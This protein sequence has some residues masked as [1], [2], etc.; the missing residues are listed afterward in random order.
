MNA[1]KGQSP[2]T[3]SRDNPVPLESIL[4]TDQL[5][6]RP[7]RPADHETENRAL[8]ALA[9]A[10][11][12]SPPTILQKL[13]EIILEVLRAQSAGL[14]LLTKE[15]GGKRF[16]WPAIAGIWKQHVGGGTPRE[17]GPC[18]DVLDRDAP[19]LFRH[20]E[21]RYAY[22]QP[23]TPPVEECL[24]VPFYVEGKAVGTIWGIMHDTSRV[25]DAEDLRQLESLGRFAS[26]AYQAVESFNALEQRA[27]AVRQS[28]ANLRDF[29]ENA[30]IGLHWVGPDGIIIWA[31]QTEL[32]MLG[33]EREEYIGHDIAK[34]HV[35]APVIEDIL[36]RLTDGE[37]LCDYEARLRCKDGSIRTVH[38]NSNAFFEE[39]KFV[40]T[41]CFTHDITERKQSE[42]ALR[43]SEER[44]RTLFE[45]GP[46]AVYSCDTA[47]VIQEFN[48]RAA[49]LWGRAPELGDTDERF[50]GSFRLHRPDGTFMPHEQCPMAEVL[51]GKIPATHDAEVII[52]RPDGSRITVIVNIRPLKDEQGEV[53][54]A[55]NCF[56][57][58]TERVQAAEALRM[59]EA[60]KDAIL[61]S[62]L[63]AIITMDHEGRVVEFNPAAERI[64]GQA[65]EAVLGKPLAEVIIP[66]RM[67]ES[68]N[69]GLQHYLTTG[70]G[71]I[72]NQQIELTA[73]RAD[74]T[75]F[76]AELAIIVIPGI[77]PPIFTA[78]LRDV[79]GRKQLEDS[80]HARA[81]ELARAD[82]SKDEFLAM[83]AHELRNPLAPLRNASE[84]LQVAGVSEEERVQAQGIISRQI[85]NM[86]RMIDD[87]LDV[88]RIAEGKI[89]LRKKPVALDAVLTAAA[90]L[91]RAACAARK[92]ELMVSLPAEPVFLNADATRLEQIFGN[93][94]NNASRYS[95]DGSHIT[96]SAE[97]AHG[98]VVVKVTDDG[99][100]IAREILPHIFGLFV[101]A[102]RTL[103]RQHGG[104][105]I[106]LTLVQRLV[107]LH[108]GTIE[109]RSE[110][111]GHGAEFIVRLPIS[112]EAPSSA[113]IP[114][115]ACHPRDFPPHPH[116]GRQ[117]RLRTQ[118]RRSA[119]PPGSRDTHGLHRSRGPRSRRGVPAGSCPARHRP[120]RHGR[121]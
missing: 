108:D 11:A 13:A 19:L 99:E 16:H 34:F 23:V 70:G 79:T 49:E 22:F 33:Y 15:D 113:P 83:L 52:E 53:T 24:L 90:S 119:K 64:F 62:A 45:L 68:H 48:H 42:E 5:T 8:V 54:G 56:Y 77:E 14:S 102:S 115:P 107:K 32:N 109:A 117:H 92:Q 25:F 41:R 121:L 18:G 101:Q 86:G 94:L 98:E 67:R 72:L 88:S 9:Q 7:R 95:G 37:M 38:I 84:I 55:I 61:S 27:E 65:R 51:C 50:C 78:F 21:R 73:L 93:L 29:L 114:S 2:P 17:F 36:K 81:A 59:S 103:D 104:L 91:V 118:S 39:G 80:L 120:S 110:G 20:V 57:D 63:D 87:L 35:D 106:G 69:Q 58:I 96:L 40:H 26:A 46:V 10:L 105:G 43:R 75:E 31:N 4:C 111:L 74:G 76:P 82:R 100:G 85:E 28:E 60:R 89:A 6:R 3:L 116:R 71:P 66:E 1:P 12:D 30:S 47:G 112:A 44:F 97:R